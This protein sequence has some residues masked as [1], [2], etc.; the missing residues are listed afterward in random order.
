[1]D[2]PRRDHRG[3]TRQQVGAGTCWV[4]PSARVTVTTAEAAC[5]VA[6]HGRNEQVRQKALLPPLLPSSRIVRNVES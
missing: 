6:A 5:A 2:G 1:V 4:L 3:V